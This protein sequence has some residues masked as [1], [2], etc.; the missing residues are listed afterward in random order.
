LLS[1][2]TQFTDGKETATRF[3]AAM[4]A[5][6]SAM[7]RIKEAEDEPIEGSFIS[8]HPLSGTPN[9]TVQVTWSISNDVAYEPTLN[10]EIR[11]VTSA[12]VL[13]ARSPLDT[14]D[15]GEEGAARRGGIFK[16][17]G[18]TTSTVSITCPP[19]PGGYVLALYDCT[20]HKRILASP[21]RVVGE[22]PVT[23][24]VV[25][26]SASRV[27]ANTA[28]T[29]SFSWAA[30]DAAVPA[31]FPAVEAIAA[32]LY[33]L[34]APDN[35]GYMVT[36]RTGF[37]DA[38]DVQMLDRGA[39][40]AQTV[41]FISPAATG[42]YEVRLLGQPVSVVLCTVATSMPL[43]VTAAACST[44]SG[45]S[46]IAADVTM[47]VVGAELQIKFSLSDKDAVASLMS[48][49]DHLRFFPLGRSEQDVY[50]GRL[51][52]C[53]GTVAPSGTLTVAA[54]FAEG[55][56]DVALRRFLDNETVVLS[57]RALTT[58]LPEGSL[59]VSAP[60]GVDQDATR[61]IEIRTPTPGVLCDEDRLLVY[62]E[63][64]NVVMS[65]FAVLVN[66]TTATATIK[67]NSAG[68]FNVNYY[69][70]RLR[71][72]MPWRPQKLLTVSVASVNH[73]P[74]ATLLAMHTLPYGTA[75]VNVMVE[76]AADNDW[77][78]EDEQARDVVALF[79]RECKESVPT[80]FPDDPLATPAITVQYLRGRAECDLCFDVEGLACGEYSFRY[81]VS[82]GRHFLRVCVSEVHFS[83]VDPMAN[84]ASMNRAARVSGATDAKGLGESDVHAVGHT[85]AAIEQASAAELA[86]TEHRHANYLAM[87][88]AM[89]GTGASRQLSRR[90]SLSTLTKTQ[91]LRRL[92]ANSL[93]QATSLLGTRRTSSTYVQL[94]PKSQGNAPTIR[95][96]LSGTSFAGRIYGPRTATTSEQVIVTYHVT[97]GDQ[98]QDDLILLLNEDCT[99]ILSEVPLALTAFSGGDA[100]HGTAILNPA[101]HPGKYVAGYYSQRYGAVVLLSER[102]RLKASAAYTATA[103]ARA[104]E[105]AAAL[106]ASQAAEHLREQHVA[107]PSALIELARRHQ[108][109]D[110]QDRPP[111]LRALLAGC[112]YM[113]QRAEL[114]GPLNDLDAVARSLARYGLVT[115][116]AAGA[117]QELRVLHEQ[118][119]PGLQ[120]TAANIRVGLRWLARDAQKGDHLVFYFSGAGSRYVGEGERCVPGA[121]SD[122]GLLPTDYDFA[123]RMISYSE[124]RE[125]L[126]EAV[127]QHTHV[128]VI[129][130]ACFSST[131]LDAVDLRDPAV[132]IR[133][134]QRGLPG[135]EM[136][137]AGRT[138]EQVAALGKWRAIVAPTPAP[139]TY[140]QRQARNA[141]S[142]AGTA[143]CHGLTK[144]LAPAESSST[145]EE[146]AVSGAAEGFVLFEAARECVD[147]TNGAWDVF[148]RE[149]GLTMGLFTHA[150]CRVLDDEAAALGATA[151]LRWYE[152][153]ERVA[154]F[155]RRCPEGRHQ[156]PRLSAGS[157]SSLDLPV[158]PLLNVDDN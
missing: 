124:I 50:D 116:A 153:A 21:F 95:L 102:V 82:L 12:G 77:R 5:V 28:F 122:C 150:L 48:P 80:Q 63:T 37:T 143:P 18:G 126:Y 64:A 29:A 86:V 7:R 97:A 69:S 26:L 44:V 152:L 119:A 115:D 16:T 132:A 101:R 79:P 13:I 148:I 24:T 85:P 42:E 8:A 146:R 76:K 113:K 100:T 94:S 128:T 92:S 154:R 70:A 81:M 93:P 151:A 129:V 140:L 145:V 33:K 123:H 34:D 6:K 96:H 52:R 90:G 41:S 149:D 136:L 4:P 103:A 61:V 43:N 75:V 142:G 57:R 127:P 87:G 22:R 46:T 147:G 73:M 131:A 110:V 107:V 98:R 155:V 20:A 62:D 133:P 74:S 49:L 59:F 137:T 91:I 27:P 3:D 89:A 72:L 17:A 68:K 2:A 120:P 88:E 1:R 117:P 35:D 19:F 30:V 45:A 135:V 58:K 47:C 83:I 141:A 121:A 14:V 66:D 53:L 60:Y 84:P 138:R 106:S 104:A 56:Y 54:P 15:P 78:F 125:T 10:D 118:Q 39:A 112:S 32:A 38:E 109:R 156:L 51:V 99:R 71:Q 40:D 25:D 9:A 23:P 11:L 134:S 65:A 55:C 105:A 67:L 36:G 111:R 114:G 108:F 139:M 31:G 158:F 130:D 157:P 144:L